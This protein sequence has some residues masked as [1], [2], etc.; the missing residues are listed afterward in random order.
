MKFRKTPVLESLFNKVAGLQACNV[1]IKET[2]TQ[3]FSCEIC[4]T[5]KNNY[6]EEHLQTTASIFQILFV[7]FLR[8][9]TMIDKIFQIEVT[10]V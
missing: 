8:T 2:P 6:F 10:I 9:G 5:F 3:V 4:E 1:I 7:V